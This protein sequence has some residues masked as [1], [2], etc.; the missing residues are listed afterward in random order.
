MCV[1][2]KICK[3]LELRISLIEIKKTERENVDETRCGNKKWHFYK[4]CPKSSHRSFTSKRDSFQ[5]KHKS[6]R[7]FELLLLQI[8]S[9]RTLKI[10]QSGHTGEVLSNVL[11]K[12]IR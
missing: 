6:N 8:L 10:A 12:Q 1:V 4:S 7:Q 9:P 2:Q 3:L 11:R 5:S